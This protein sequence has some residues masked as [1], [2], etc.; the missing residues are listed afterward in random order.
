MCRRRINTSNVTR[1]KQCVYA[2]LDNIG[3]RYRSKIN[4]A[5]SGGGE[6][7]Y[8]S[9]NA[10]IRIDGVTEA[11]EGSYNAMTCTH[12]EMTALDNY[13]SSANKDK[14]IN[15]I[16]I[17]SPP[18]KS[19]AFVLELLGLIGV[20]KT[21]GDIYKHFTSSWKWPVSLQDKSIFDVSRWS[22]IKTYFNDSGLDEDEI[23][24]YVVD[25]VRTNSPL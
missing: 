9:C 24:K 23:L 16:E 7:N 20:V 21:T 5:L 8:M 22:T 6:D 13:F 17:S 4:T 1:G 11:I 2:A 25:V 18:C 15:C 19:C 14:K 3:I 10:V 12:A